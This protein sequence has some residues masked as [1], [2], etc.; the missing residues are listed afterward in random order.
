ML[1]AVVTLMNSKNQQVGEQTV[2]TNGKFS[3]ANIPADNY[4]IKIEY[5]VSALSCWTRPLR[6]Q[7]AMASL[8]RLVLL[9]ADDLVLEGN[10]S[11]DRTGKVTDQDGKP[12]R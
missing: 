4:K 9:R 3:Y 12:R 1:G 11:T 2:I 10:S 6:I 5:P 7:T 8:I